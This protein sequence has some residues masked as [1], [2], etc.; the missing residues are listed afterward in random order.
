MCKCCSS[1]IISTINDSNALINVQRTMEKFEIPLEEIRK[2]TGAEDFDT[3]IS[4]KPCR[5][6][7]HRGKL[8]DC[9]VERKTFIKHWDSQDDI[10]GKHKRILIELLL[11]SNFHHENITPFIGFYVEDDDI[12]VASEYALNGSLY[13]KLKTQYENSYLTWAE[14]LKICLGAAKGLKGFH[15]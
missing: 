3:R 1:L 11:I 5:M 4:S 7:T 12:I 8:V 15:A 9:S 2:A 14:R 6:M 13:L 10:E